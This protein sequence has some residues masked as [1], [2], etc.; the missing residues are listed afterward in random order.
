MSILPHGFEKDQRAQHWRRK[1][2]EDLIRSLTDRAEAA[3]KKHAEL[4]AFVGYVLTAAREHFTD[5]RKPGWLLLAEARIK[6]GSE[7]V[8]V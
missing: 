2:D 7:E 1:E 8:R 4:R 6:E 5:E 3:E